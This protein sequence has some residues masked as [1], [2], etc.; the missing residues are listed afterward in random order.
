MTRGSGHNK[1]GGYTEVPAEYQQVIDRLAKKHAAAADFVP[2]PKIQ[3]A[4]QPRFGIVTLGGCDLAVREAI[5]LLAQR[6]IKA[7]YMRVCGFPFSKSVETFLN[8]H[9]VNFVVEQNRDGQLTSLLTL[10][11]SVK[12]EKLKPILFYGGF[13]LSASQVVDAILASGETNLAIDSETYS[14][15]PE[16]TTE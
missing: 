2:G 7:D 14:N 11:T 16:F 8:Q 9:A 10:E 5:G 6:G 4:F 13:P 12:K 3:T 15:A 1:F